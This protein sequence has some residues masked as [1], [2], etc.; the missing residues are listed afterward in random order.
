MAINKG[1]SSD[2][3]SSNDELRQEVILQNHGHTLLLLSMHERYYCMALSNRPHCEQE[4][5]IWA[6]SGAFIPMGE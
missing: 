5:S 1:V 3:S 4:W 2:W 6:I